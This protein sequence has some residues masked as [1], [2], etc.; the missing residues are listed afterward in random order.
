M[1][2]LK[3]IEPFSDLSPEELEGLAANSKRRSYPS[4]SIVLYKGDVGD[5]IYLILKG[6]VKVVLSNPEGKEIILN[7]FS[8]G[9]YFGEMS[10]FDHMP[11]SANIVAIED[12]EFLMIPEEA[13][14]NQIKKTPALA[15]KL[16]SIMSARLRESNE[17]I[18][19]LAHL[20][21]KGRVAHTLYK[22]FKKSGK[23]VDGQNQV[24]PRPTVKEIADM[25]GASR[26]TVS[27][28]LTEL[29][30]QRIISLTKTEIVIH[31]DLVDGDYAD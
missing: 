17:Q 10:I 16:L 5:V 19:S 20:N 29:A 14:V 25:S 28:I 30:K 11:R 2:L 15:F 21:V 23:T 1:N 6:K 24:I 3:N 4:G 9:E 26:E 13:V 8:V 22:L 12:C 27:R 7:T 18:A 31:K